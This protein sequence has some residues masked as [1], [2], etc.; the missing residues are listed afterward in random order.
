[1]LQLFHSFFF[2]L[3]HKMLKLSKNSSII[4]ST[5]KKIINYRSF[6]TIETKKANVK[7]SPFIAT[8]TTALKQNKQTWRL[9]GYLYTSKRFLNGKAKWQYSFNFLVN[10][11]LRWNTSRRISIKSKSNS[12]TTKGFRTICMSKL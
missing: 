6:H 3:I 10:F 9:T 7:L 8:T 12:G 4:R 5:P 1:M 2:F 11:L